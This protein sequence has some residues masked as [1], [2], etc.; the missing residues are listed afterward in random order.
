VS[1]EDVL[2]RSRIAKLVSARHVAM[3]LMREMRGL[4][5]PRIAERTGRGDHTS[6]L[7]GIR[8]VEATPWLLDAAQQIRAALTAPPAPT[9]PPEQGGAHG[10]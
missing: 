5:L 3:W 1:V 8:H 6:A 9:V 4:S 2:G 10:E 7:H